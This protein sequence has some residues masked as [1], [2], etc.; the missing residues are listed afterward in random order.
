MTECASSIKRLGP[1]ASATAHL[2]D[3]LSGK[4]GFPFAPMI[5]SLQLFLVRNSQ[6][7]AHAV[8]YW[9]TGAT[10]GAVAGAVSGLAAILLC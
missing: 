6:V 4:E 7:A 10:E 5:T 1:L 3:S 9:D 8:T 2:K